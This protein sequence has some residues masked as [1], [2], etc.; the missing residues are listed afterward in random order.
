MQLNTDPCPV[1][2]RMDG[3]HDKAVHDM[4]DGGA[5]AYPPAKASAR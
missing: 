5:K 2:R 1:C 4:V 3:G